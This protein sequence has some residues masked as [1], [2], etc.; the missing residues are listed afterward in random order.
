MSEETTLRVDDS[1]KEL[2]NSLVSVMQCFLE[3]DYFTSMT[4]LQSIGSYH[5]LFKSTCSKIFREE[6]YQ[7][8][9][10]F[11]ILKTSA[12][13][14]NLNDFELEEEISSFTCGIVSHL[15]K[16]IADTHPKKDIDKRKILLLNLALTLEVD[17]VFNFVS[18]VL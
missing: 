12:S 6:R 18:K 10:N 9:S 5:L 4:L 16:G 1:E 17:D 14:E 13:N 8:P 7:L 15:V 2:L 11:N 3:A